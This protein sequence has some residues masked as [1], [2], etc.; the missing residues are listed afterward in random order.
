MTTRVSAFNPTGYQRTEFVIWG[1]D[2]ERPTHSYERAPGGCVNVGRVTVPAFHDGMVEVSPVTSDTPMRIHSAIVAAGPVPYVTT[3]SGRFLFQPV[4]L[5]A[6]TPSH[7]VHLWRARTPEGVAE[8]VTYLFTNQPTIRWE[9]G[10]WCESLSV[11]SR[12]IDLA[13]G[14]TAGLGCR[15]LT[16]D[17]PAPAAQE[18]QLLTNK[19]IGDSQGAAWSGV[20]EC[21]DGSL[22]AEE[23][24]TML[25]QAAYPLFVA[26]RWSR[27]GPW[28]K[29]PPEVTQAQVNAEFGANQGKPWK[30]PFKWCEYILNPNPGDTGE[31]AEFGGWH[32]VT[33]V[34]SGSAKLLWQQHG[35]AMRETCRPGRYFEPNGSWVMA[36]AHP[37]WVTWSG[38][39][40]WH[41]GVSPDRL[42][43]T[44]TG[45]IVTDGWNHWDDQHAGGIFASEQ[46]LL[47]GSYLLR[48]LLTHYCQN[49][50]AGWTLPSTHPD[51]WQSTNEPGPGRAVG[52][53]FMLMA[54]LLR[55]G[56]VVPKDQVV[57]QALKRFAECVYPLHWGP[58]ADHTGWL[59]RSMATDQIRPFTIIGPDPRTTFPTQDV[60]AP[61]QDAICAAGLDAFARTLEDCGV[62]APAAMVEMGQGVAKSVVV[63]GYEPSCAQSVSYMPIP[64]NAPPADYHNPAL[65]LLDSG[66]DFAR[67]DLLGVGV[68]ERRES[69][70]A[71]LA[72]C[73]R[74]EALH[75]PRAR[76][77]YTASIV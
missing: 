51:Y 15:L 54:H 62:P 45:R 6:A 59:G 56:I 68:L 71:L 26:E 35:A 74:I 72:R 49:R 13:F 2:S 20:I 44:H 76:D 11:G 30:D 37:R 33:T 29:A 25:A 66:T 18:I 21:A 50:I 41:P 61:W 32:H 53:T 55:S 5:M 46:C 57:V 40:H 48:A 31:Q 63:H 4:Q 42:G 75:A 36:A 19:T 3:R 64:G 39:T 28:S 52:R 65:C 38:E 34:G 1:S 69:D 17:H 23:R 27:W 10:F 60:W 16:Y 8:L 47:T 70:T 67:W 14:V 73:D 58:H 12:A 24:D 43:R 77:T 22:T 7:A 9:M